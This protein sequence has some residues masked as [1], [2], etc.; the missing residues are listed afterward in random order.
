MSRV[1]ADKEELNEIARTIVN[2]VENIV[3]KNKMLTY[4]DKLSDIYLGYKLANE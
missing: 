3:L 2:E 4:I 1:E